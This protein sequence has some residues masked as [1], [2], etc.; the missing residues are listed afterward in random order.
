MARPR[1]TTPTKPDDARVQRSIDLLSNAFLSLLEHKSL[2]EISIRD[3]TDEAGVSYPTFFRRFDGKDDLLN[4][5]AAKEIRHLLNLGQSTITRPPEEDSGT[6]LCDYVQAHRK[7]WKTLLNGGAAL[8]MREEFMR[9]A[10]QIADTR[11]RA[12]PWLPTDLAVPFVTSGIFE[13]IAWWMRMPEDYPEE[14]VITLFNAL[15]IDS[16]RRPRDIKLI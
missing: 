6:E 15:I 2:E 5:I 14:N 12:N 1:T 7:L 11:E 16:V 13:I 10:R 4:H 9:T 8:A 3:I